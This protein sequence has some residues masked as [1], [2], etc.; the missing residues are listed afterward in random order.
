MSFEFRGRHMP[1]ATLSRG[2][3]TR[4]RAQTGPHQ[5]R[6]PPLLSWPA[7]Q[8]PRTGGRRRAKRPRPTPSRRR[9][10][11]P[12]ASAS[13]SR[14]RSPR[15]A[16][17][18]RRNVLANSTHRSS[19]GS[20]ISRRP[21]RRCRNGSPSVTPCSRRQ[22]T[23]SSPSMPGCSRKT[24]PFNSAPWTTRW[25]RRS[26]ANSSPAA[27]GAIL[28]EMEAERASKLASFLSGA[29]GG[30]EKILMR[31]IL[32]PMLLAIAVSAAGCWNSA[33]EFMREPF[34]SPVGAGL[35]PEETAGIQSAK[36]CRAATAV[37]R[38]AAVIVQPTA[39]RPCRRHRAGAHLDQRQGDPRTTP[40]AA[41]RQTRTE[42]SSTSATTA[43]RRRPHPVSPPRLSATCR[44]QS[45]TQGQGNIDRS[46]Q[47]QVSVAAVVTRV[48]PNGN[49]VISGS[50]EVRVNYEL[51]QLTV[52]GIVNPLDISL[53]NSV[54]YDRIAEAR[55]AYGGRGR[56]N[57]FQQ[58]RL[59]PADLRRRQAILAGAP[60]S[61]SAL[62]QRAAARK[63]A[64][65][66]ADRIGGRRR[67]GRLRRR[68]VRGVA[69]RRAV[70]SG[71]A[72]GIVGRPRRRRNLRPSSICRR[73]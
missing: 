28:D 37:E 2:Q 16:S 21:R 50:Q 19:S 34:F 72:R 5:R 64:Q 6:S 24:R 49:L 7:R 22:A 32:P 63:P 39:H 38:T 17:P 1:T 68:C 13:T 23:I 10:P 53:N 71:Q 61:D 12:V 20:P 41:R 45:T 11:K 4:S 60:M 9:K 66:V 36:L 42:S 35:A 29:N 57:D 8:A 51:R 30:R 26:W 70:R 65:V 69:P 14:R 52:A 54:A 56:S 44:P 47:I 46:E 48:L 31:L 59:G 18:G 62:P 25:R 43:D 73:S 15:R 58:P 33:S 55:I 67:F 40:R 3:T 27:A